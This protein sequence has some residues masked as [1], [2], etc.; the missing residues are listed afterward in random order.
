ML[1][2]NL[3]CPHCIENPIS[4]KIFEMPQ[5][6]QEIEP[7]Q[8]GHPVSKK[9]RLWIKGLP[10]LK[11]TCVVTPAHN[12]HEAYT[13]FMKGGKNRQVNR[14]KTFEGVAKAMADQWA[15]LVR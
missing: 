15:D 11:P 7:W 10:L 1:F 3:S 13:W 5:F 8:F 9:T 12:C 4:S 14:A 6:S 2:Y